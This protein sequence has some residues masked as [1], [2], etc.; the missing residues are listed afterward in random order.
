MTHTLFPDAATTPPT[1]PPAKA[2]GKKK[3]T[4]TPTPVPYGLSST[5]AY[6]PMNPERDSA[7]LEKAPLPTLGVERTGPHPQTRKDANDQAWALAQTLPHRHVLTDDERRILQAHSGG[8]NLGESTD[9]YYTPTRLAYLTWQVIRHL[10]PKIRTALEPACGT[11]AFLTTAPAGLRLTACEYDEATARIAQLLNPATHVLHTP[12]E[13]YHATSADPRPDVVIGNPPYGTRGETQHADPRYRHLRRAEQYFLLAGLER[14]APGGLLAYVL[15]HALLSDNHARFRQDLLQS[16]TVLGAF[17]IPDGAFKATGASLSTVLLI[18]RKHDHGVPEALRCLTPDL[19]DK[20]YSSTDRTFLAGESCIKDGRVEWPHLCKDTTVE[21]GQYGQPIVRGEMELTQRRLEAIEFAAKKNYDSAISAAALESLLLTHADEAT[22][23]AA[24]K[25][26][27]EAGRFPIPEG[28]VSDCRSF[29]FRRGQWRYAS[30]LATPEAQLVIDLARELQREQIRAVP[31]PVKAE[32]F[33]RLK[34]LASATGETPTEEDLAAQARRIGI[35]ARTYPAANLVL[36]PPKVPERRALLILPGAVPDVAAQLARGWDLTRVNLA[37][38]AGITEEDAGAFLLANYRFDGQRWVPPFEYD[39]GHAY[40]K[41]RLA[42]EQARKWRPDLPEHAA[43]LKQADELESRAL[44]QAKSITDTP[45]TPRDPLIPA[46]V[47]QAWVNTYLQTHDDQGQPRLLVT[48]DRGLT[49]LVLRHGHANDRYRVDQNVTARLERYLNHDTAVDRIERQDM[50]PEQ[51]EAQKS[52]VLK[53]AVRYERSLEAHFRQWLQSSEHASDVEDVYNRTRNAYLTGPEDTSLLHIPEWKGP[54]HHLYQRG[55]IRTLAAWGHGLLAYDV[56]LGKTYT[57]LG[58]LSVL[59][60]RG[61]ARRPWIVTPLSLT[62]NWVMNAHVARPDWTVMVIG[63]NPTGTYDDEGL[64]E[65]TPDSTPQRKEK[66]ARLLNEDVDLVVISMEAFTDIPLLEETRLSL[67]ESDAAQLAQG[68]EQEEFSVGQ[69]AFRGRKALVKEEDF[70]ANLMGKGKTATATDLPFELFA[71]DVLIFEEGHKFKNLFEAP[72]YLGAKPK[73]MGAGLASIRAYDAYL[74]ARWVRAQ[75]EGR[76]TYSLTGTPYKN[77]PLEVAYALALTTDDL[78]TFGLNTPAAFMLQYCLIEPTI[79]TKPDGS[80]GTRP[81]VVGFKNLKELR[82]L[83]NAHI[84]ARDAETCKLDHRIGLPLPPLQRHIHTL[85]LTPQQEA[86]YIPERRAAQSPA[87]DGENHLF[88]IYNRMQQLILHPEASCGGRNPRAEKAAELALDAERTGHKSLAFMDRGG[89]GGDES[90]FQAYRAAYIRAGIPAGAIEIITATTHKDAVSR[91]A[92]EKRYRRGEVRHILGSS[93]I[94]EGFNLQHLTKHLI[95]LDLP[96]DPQDIKQRDGRGWRQGNPA[97]EIHS[98]FLLARGS[99][100]ALAYQNVMG[101]KGW[102]DHLASE[103]DTG[104]NPVAFQAAQTAMLLAANPEDV[105]AFVRAQEEAMRAEALR[106]EHHA[107]WQ[108]VERFLT[109]ASLLRERY[110]KAQ[111]RKNGPTRQDE[112]GVERLSGELHQTARHLMRLPEGMRRAIRF[113][114]TITWHEGLP[115]ASGT[116]F[117]LKGESYTIKAALPTHVTT[118]K[119]VDVDLE[120]LEQAT[121]VA[122]CAEDK[123]FTADPLVG[124][125]DTVR[126]EVQAVLDAEPVEE[127]PDAPQEPEAPVT[128][129]SDLP[130]TSSGPIMYAG[131]RTLHIVLRATVAHVYRPVPG[132]LQPISA[133]STPPEGVM[134][135]GV[136]EDRVELVAAART[137]AMLQQTWDMDPVAILDRVNML[138]AHLG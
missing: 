12:F 37:R 2:K 107:Q 74:K 49:R 17:L 53:K 19:R 130:V 99:Y 112:Q 33:K 39:F 67:I 135:L 125:P 102:L 56:G 6:T 23:T 101:K 61:E 128:E 100:D 79:V 126:L 46:E 35:I 52:A 69:T 104:E 24:L 113:N 120:A 38:E 31:S 105:A 81:A 16:A 1:T 75:Q 29:V 109:T 137:G 22:R 44:A 66:L 93:I 138:L 78:T 27:N 10:D 34:G 73:F 84:I 5:P 136:S 97:T 58:L 96:H 132:G 129:P 111:G 41:A 55:D 110:A 54:G 94:R 71:P 89:D 116:T 85:D 80:V 86:A 87:Q 76:G 90:A 98:H 106:L 123:F 25:A 92:A 64:P 118:T 4:P 3:A 134:W 21:F 82:T 57:A 11:G 30:L 133:D 51:I 18:L 14:L 8:G 122:L 124:L 72:D 13:P 48:K 95:H 42:R 36:H 91:L 15:P 32:M 77:S 50:S 62:G 7:F 26:M 63:M 9:A 83:M 65:F 45:I 59:K 70:L 103:S 117:T 43:L 88:A 114:G 20:L 127:E 47:L 119:R 68:A 40:D 121:D 60:Q 131:S 28:T 115:L 108:V